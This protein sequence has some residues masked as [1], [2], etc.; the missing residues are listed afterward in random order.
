DDRNRCVAPILHQQ[1][2][3]VADIVDHRLLQER[4]DGARRQVV[5]GRY[6]QLLPHPMYV[7]AIIA[8]AGRS[9]RLSG[10]TPKQLLAV[11]GRSLLE[12]SVAAFVTHGSVDEIVV[13][14]PADLVPTPPAYL[15]SPAKPVRVVSGGERRQDSVGNAFA[16]VDPRA[17][18]VLIHDAARPFVSAAL[19]DRTI[20]AAHETGA[21]VAAVAARDTVKQG[22]IA[23]DGARGW[24]VK[25]TLPRESIFLVQT[26]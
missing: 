5:G 24:I 3:R 13:A 20:A 1:T 17:E 14:L 4:L 8:A 12:R 9:A 19:I 2:D 26:P 15:R 7:T 22:T 18:I 16:A 11:A 10:G 25:T 21:A 23:G 6:N